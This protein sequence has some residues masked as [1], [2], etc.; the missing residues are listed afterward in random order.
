MSSPGNVF[1]C[2]AG[3]TLLGWLHVVVVVGGGGGCG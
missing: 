3:D 2:G 1:G